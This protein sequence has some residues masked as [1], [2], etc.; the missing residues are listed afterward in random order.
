MAQPYL[1]QTTAMNKILFL[2]LFL[3]IANISN[4]QIKALTETGKEVLLFDNGTWKYSNDSSNTDNKPDSISLNAH[5]FSKTA[6]QTFLVKSKVF[7]VGIYINPSKWT[8]S[9]HRD[10]ESNPEYR[11]SLK[12]GDGFAMM[13]TEKT[14]IDLENMRQIALLNA[15]KASIDAKETSAE[16]RMVNN[17]KILC[18]TMQGTIK[19][20]KFAYLGYYYSN[21]NGTIQLVSYSSQKLFETQKKEFEELLNGLVE[22]DNK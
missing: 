8:F 16:Y 14:T 4:A 17:K 13:I 22:L 10:N 18:L 20:I 1:P 11:F 3:S 21:S 2:F 12:S 19:G 6:G 9:S 5:S 15:Q 7:N